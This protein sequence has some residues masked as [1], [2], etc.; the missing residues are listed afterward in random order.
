MNQPIGHDINGRPL[1]V[2]HRPA[3]ESFGEMMEYLVGN[4]RVGVYN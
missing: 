1:R 4:K 3:N 2:N